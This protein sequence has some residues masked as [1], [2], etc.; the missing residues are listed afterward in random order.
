M[1]QQQVE[2]NRSFGLAEVSPG[3]EAQA[4]VDGSRVE[5][6]KL[7]LETKLLLF[8]RALVAAKVQ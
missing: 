5:T 3:K 4:E 2:L 1:V 7:I 8:T 6:E